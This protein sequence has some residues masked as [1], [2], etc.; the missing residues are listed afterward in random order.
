MTVKAQKVW[1]G[2][3]AVSII[4]RPLHLM[5]L[6]GGEGAQVKIL[7]YESFEGEEEVLFQVE[8]KD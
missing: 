2:R 4:S 5:V 6:G 3:N 8:L 7:D 1:G